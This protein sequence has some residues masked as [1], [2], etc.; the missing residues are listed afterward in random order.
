MGT[1]GHRHHHGRGHFRDQSKRSAKVLGALAVFTFVF[2]LVEIIGGL[3]ASSLALLADAGHMFVDTSALVLAA[4]AA[5]LATRPANDKNT[6]GYRRAE[7]IGAFLNAILLYGMVVYVAMESIQRLWDQPEI[8]G[9]LMLIVAC[10]GLGINLIA[11]VFLLRVR[12]DS[13]DMN[14][15]AALIHVG[16][17]SL[18]SVGAIL[19]SLAV[20]Y[21]GWM[22]ADAAAGLTVATLV[23]IY[24]GRLFYDALNIL[25]QR[26]PK[27]LDV[28][29]IGEVIVAL[30]GIKNVHDIHIWAL[31]EGE[32]NMT[33]HLVVESAQ[34]LEQWDDLLVDVNQLL[35]EHFDIHHTTIQPE[36]DPSMHEDQFEH[37]GPIRA[38]V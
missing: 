19:A 25:L 36:L 37:L 33:A 7:V 20:M 29:E 14:L 13:K 34:T 1:G 11:I 35:S 26:V 38:S 28:Q 23:G 17:D 9:D 27:H 4:I 10:I 30:D 6:F 18:G 12:G 24:A 3:I 8:K 32:I 31:A 16:S 5:S 15:R 22:W 2:M 21:F